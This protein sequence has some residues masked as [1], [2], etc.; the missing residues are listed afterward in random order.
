MNK[1]LRKI[2]TCGVC[3]TMAAVFT[4]G[5]TPGG[6][7]GTGAGENPETRPFVMAIG[8]TDGNFSPFFAT[9]QYDVQVTELTQISMLTAD[10]NG[11][12]TYGENEPSVVL[13]M[14]ESLYDDKDCKV[15]SSSGNMDGKSVYEFVI[16]NGIKFSNGSDL[17]I[18][19]VLFNL[20][21]YLDPM[22]FGSSTIYSTN[23][24]GLAKYRNQDPLLDDDDDKDIASSFEADAMTRINALMEYIE[25]GTITSTTEAQI[26]EDIETLK[27]MFL[28]EVTSDWTAVYGTLDSY[29]KEYS[30]TSNWEVYY[31]NEGL[32]SVLYELQGNGNRVDKKDSNGKYLTT[33]DDKYEDGTYK[34]DLREEMQKALSNEERIS[35]LMGA[36]LNLTRKGALDYIE[37]ETAIKTV[38]E[39]KVKKES[40]LPLLDIFNE[41]WATAG[42]FRDQIAKQLMSDYFDNNRVNGALKV[43]NISGITTYQTS[44]FYGKNLGEPHDVLKVEINGVDPKAIYN[45]AFQVAPA[46]YYSGVFTNKDGVTVDY[47]KIDIAKNQFGVCMGT[48]DFFDKVLNDPAKSACPVGAGTY[49]TCNSTGTPT[50]N[51]DA[52]HPGNT[53][54]YYVRNEYFET[55]GKGISNAKIKYVRYREVEDSQLVNILKSGEVDYG[56]PSCTQ[57]NIDNLGGGD[58]T[59]SY[60]TPKSSGYGYVGINPKYVP[61]IYVRRAIIQA[62]N[63]GNTISF[64]TEEY[65]EEIYRPMSTANWLHN[66]IKD[67]GAYYEQVVNPATIKENLQKKGWDFSSGVGKRD[68]YGTLKYTFTIAG[69]STDH[70]AYLMFNEAAKILNKAGFDISVTTDTNAL[71]SLATGALQVWAAAY[72]SPVDPDL[73]QVY[74]K[75]SKATSVMNWGYD[76]I[77]ENSRGIYTYEKGV[78]DDLSDK[79]MEARQTTSEQERGG[80]YREALD[81]IMELAIQLPTYQRNDLVVYNRALLDSST[82]NGGPTAYAG[83]LNRIWEVN[84]SK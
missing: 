72:T 7:S 2:L 43:A 12:I 37:R 36:P 14:K 28:E 1:K 19:D 69:S 5:C 21:V 23:I 66:Y 74:H 64:Y 53:F 58:V 79:I 45:M 70:P 17:T 44:T 83:V 49:Q 9:A 27:T 10:E 82:L 16:K 24:V 40:Y 50:T 67:Q 41:G 73:Y 29:T 55:V 39:S 32:I 47:R 42:N 59:L 30:F 34:S 63:I 22:Y 76:V 4:A 6:S 11:K 25:K 62:M 56:E 65:A 13:D 84:Y 15:P 68:G 48:S 75:D 52:F 33:L 26:K 78:L 35:E 3:L 77:K 54:S 57:D 51:G 20:Y 60:K 38:Y 18:K 8:A 46:Y 81:L 31:L 80:I 71:K 61:D